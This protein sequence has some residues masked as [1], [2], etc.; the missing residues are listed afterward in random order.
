VRQILVPSENEARDV[1]RRLS[2]DPKSFEQLAR[3][4]SRAPDASTGGLMG[5]SRA[6]SYPPSWRRQCLPWRQATRQP[7]CRRRTVSTSSGS[8]SDRGP[9]RE[10]GREPGEDPCLLARQ[11]WDKRVQDF[12]RAL[13]TKA[14]VKYENA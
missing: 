7:S 1:R 5:R 10:P 2:R 6:A 4:L 13:M 11:R 8:M 3:T 12:V 9:R 14:K